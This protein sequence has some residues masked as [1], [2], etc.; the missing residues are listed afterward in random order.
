M[1]NAD[2]LGLYIHL[3]FCRVH[4]TYCPF[5][6][7]TDLALQDRYFDALISEI[8]DRSPGRAA[9]QT[10]YLGGGTPSRSSMANL[11]RLAA[12]LQER[13][14]VAAD[15]EFTIEANPEDITDE[16]LAAW[17]AMGANRVSIGV[18]SFRDHE[19]APLGRVHGGA[20]AVQAVRAAVASGLRTTVDLMLGLPGQTRESFRASL[21]QAIDAGMGHLSLYMLD[22]EEGTTLHGQVKRGRAVLP[23]DDLVAEL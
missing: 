22:L 18:Q 13:F 5:A 15:A 19:L 17:Q 14:D 2:S 21:S 4:C 7:S 9:V 20:G 1:P 12:T 6:I 11:L 8:A 16:A 23:E 10:L 3:P